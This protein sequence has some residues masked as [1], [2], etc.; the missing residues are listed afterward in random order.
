MASRFWVGGTGTWDNSTTTHWAATTGGA[1]GQSVPGSGDTV[2]FDGSSGGGTVTPNYDM[3]V[4]SITM[5]AFT[6]T[7]DFSAN[8]NNPTMTTFSCSGSGTRTLNMGSGIWTITGNNATIWNFGTQ[9]NLTQN[10]NTSTV[11]FTYSGSTGTRA[12]GAGSP[13]NFYNCLFTAGSDSVTLANPSN[14]TGNLDFTGFSGIWTNASSPMNFSGSL[15]LG[16]GMTVTSG[17]GLFTFNATSGTKTITSNSVQC[18]HPITING[19]GGTFQLGDNLDMSGASSRVLTLTNGTFATNS[20]TLKS[21]TFA[22]G[23]GTKTLTLTGSDVYTLVGTGTVWD[24]N[25]NSSGF[26]FNPNTSTIKMTDTTNTAITFAGGGET[27]ANIYWNRSSST[28]TNTITGTN[29]FA[30]FKDDGSAAHTIVFPNATTTVSTFTV[31]GTS[32]HLITLSRTGGSGTFTLSA[33]SGTISRDYLSISNSAATGGAE[34]YAGANSTDGG[35]NSG[36]LFQAP[37]SGATTGTQTNLG[38]LGFQM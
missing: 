18:N 37:T 38:F 36:W 11:K 22:L 29:T 12:I 19:S 17:T 2:T 27:F 31:S 1:G 14:F 9:T 34:W 32:G 21:G 28:A 4:T 10:V 16:S 24:T 3:T 6:G 7:L 23:S 26:T 15:T 30:D 5:G 13:V 33:P 25:T 8:N 35:G 20:H